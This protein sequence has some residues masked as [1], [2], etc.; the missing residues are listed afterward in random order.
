MEF[1]GELLDET[2]SL[3]QRKAFWHDVNQRVQPMAP[4][5]MRRDGFRL[6]TADHVAQEERLGRAVFDFDCAVLDQMP[7]GAIIFDFGIG[8]ASE[9]DYILYAI[10]LGLQPRIWDIESEALSRGIAK[11]QSLLKNVV[12]APRPEEIISF[13][14]MYQI[15]SMELPPNL[16]G[17]RAFRI[18]QHFPPI[19]RKSK[20]ATIGEWITRTRGH[21][22]FLHPFSDDNPGYK[23]GTSFAVSRSEFVQEIQAKAIHPLK[24]SR[25]KQFKY[26]VQTYTVFEIARD[27]S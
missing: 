6:T 9:K 24:I 10:R 5:F 1:T 3:E 20:L 14:D 18:L 27:E 15:L 23:Y 8:L 7:L 16:K 22:W 11:L 4:D 2:A 12:D 25:Q 26:Y 19:I 21:A 17:I 13:G